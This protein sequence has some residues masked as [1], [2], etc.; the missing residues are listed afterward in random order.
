MKLLFTEKAWDDYLWLEDNNDQL[1]KRANSLLK[2][3]QRNPFTGIGKPEFLKGTL[4]GF[5]SRRI[6]QEH[7]IIYQI[8]DDTVILISFL[9]HYK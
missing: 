8:K 2:D 6:N 4:Q 9:F 5:M 7:R 3:I 1:L